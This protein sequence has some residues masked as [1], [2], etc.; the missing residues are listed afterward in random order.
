M[1]WPRVAYMHWYT[2][3]THEEKNKKRIKK[4]RYSLLAEH[5]YIFQEY[6]CNILQEYILYLCLISTGNIKHLKKLCD[7]VNIND[8]TKTA[9]IFMGK[10]M[11]M[12]QDYF[13]KTPS[14]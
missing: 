1:F 14:F 3:L 13:G 7:K 9:D 11:G 10:D 4:D 2:S 5:S 6:I 8:L 12:L